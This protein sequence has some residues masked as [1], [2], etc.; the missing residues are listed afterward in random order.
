MNNILVKTI[1]YVLLLSISIN[2]QNYNDIVLLTEPGLGSS[3]RALGLGNS[4]LALSEDFSA[5]YFNPAGLGLMKRLEITSSI[6]YN[7]FQNESIFFD[8]NSESKITNSSFS[9]IGIVFPVPT[10]RGSFVLAAGYNVQK[11]INSSVS[12]KGFNF[13]NNSMIQDLTD[14]GFSLPYNLGLSY[15][16]ED[17]DGNYLGDET[18]IKGRLLQEGEIKNEG[19]ISSWAF[20]SALEVAPKMFVGITFNIYSG[21]YERS[22]N[23]KETDIRDFYDQDLY[24]VPGDVETANFRNF[25]MVDKLKWDISGYD[26]KFG[27]LYQPYNRIRLAAALKIPSKYTIKET[28]LEDGFSYFEDNNFTS[29]DELKNEFDVAGPLEFEF[30]GAY[31]VFNT[32]IS[33]QIKYLDYSKSKFDSGFEKDQLKYKNEDIKTFLTSTLNYNVGIEY[34][35]PKFNLRFRTGI[36]YQESP[37]KEDKKSHNKKFL[38]FGFGLLTS[39]LVSLDLGYAYGWWKNFTDNYGAGESRIYEDIKVNKI[40]FSINYRF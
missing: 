40:V 18:K 11:D 14:L 21:S 15:E 4:Y 13:G 27:W 23:Y 38:T 12:H 10:Y 30:G 1:L 26:I 9:Q 3:A 24:L 16:V 20:S 35:I 19:D 36:I 8:R 17:E 33:G 22:R 34:I 32:I 37:Y 25:R 39:R 6:N 29:E 7:N 5:V 28:Y 31:T 2:G